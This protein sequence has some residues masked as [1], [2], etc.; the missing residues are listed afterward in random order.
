[1]LTMVM[2][3]YA[4]RMNTRGATQIAEPVQLGD[5]EEHQTA[6]EVDDSDPQGVLHDEELLKSEEHADGRADA[7]RHG[8]HAQMPSRALGVVL[9][10]AIVVEVHGDR[11][12]A[13]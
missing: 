3:V 7:G 12:Q 11:G 10:P 8:Q 5:Q 4:T 13:R 2:T 6:C 9:S 1:M